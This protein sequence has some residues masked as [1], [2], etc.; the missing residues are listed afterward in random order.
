MTPRLGWCALAACA[1]AFVVP[2]SL[3]REKEDALV[4]VER[5]DKAGFF[6]RQHQAF[7]DR[8]RAGPVDLLWLGDS[9]TAGWE[10]V[11]HIWEAHYGRR[12]AANFGLGGDRTQHV[13]WRIENGE[14]DAI[15]PKL[16]VLL[17]G[18]NNSGSHSAPEIIAAL[19][20]IVTLI[21]TKLPESK[22][23]LLGIFPRGAKKDS[24][25]VVSREAEADAARR[26]RVIR[27]V[28]AGLSRFD[29]GRNVRFLDIGHVFLGQDG[30]IP[31]SIMPDQLHLSP[32]G[33]QLWADALEPGLKR[34][35]GE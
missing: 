26:M 20:K 21:R 15:A 29:D 13:I 23:L 2:A 27:E 35:L 9:I 28:N 14:L 30:R 3:A 34:M 6:L 4:G 33:Y 10:K 5:S 22:V 18:T 19:G 11:P 17:L 25:G 24:T 8:G 32:A 12:R 16:V 31:F 7:L 1:V